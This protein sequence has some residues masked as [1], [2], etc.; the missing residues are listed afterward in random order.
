MKQANTV[1]FRVAPY[2][3]KP[4]SL[5]ELI[6]MA[7]EEHLKYHSTDGMSLF[8]LAVH[9]ID[10]NQYTYPISALSLD[11]AVLIALQ[12]HT[13][14]GLPEPLYWDLLFPTPADQDIN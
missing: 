10:G 5:S 8:I 6:E 7:L 12:A 14:S 11:D 2:V 3:R 1:N 4:N 13:A 9:D